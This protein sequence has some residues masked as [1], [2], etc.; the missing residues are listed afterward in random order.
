MDVNV[1]VRSE[2]RDVNRSV[3][4]GR[5]ECRIMLGGER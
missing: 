1:V 4:R 3:K 2:R 5:N